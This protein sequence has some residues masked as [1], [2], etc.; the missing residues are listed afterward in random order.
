VC[1]VWNFTEKY[2]DSSQLPEKKI[3]ADTKSIHSSLILF[4]NQLP[5]PHAEMRIGT[6][7]HI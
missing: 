7:G 6:G 4:Q 2:R 5:H 1:V 3:L